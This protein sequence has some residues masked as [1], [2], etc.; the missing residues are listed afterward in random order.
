MT[1][2]PSNT[3]ESD[4]R[5]PTLAVVDR[6]DDVPAAEDGDD[7]AGQ[8]ATGRVGDRL[9]SIRHDRE[10][11]AA[12]PPGA[13]D[14]AFERAQRRVR[15]EAARGAGPAGRRASVRRGRRRDAGRGRVL[16]A[17][18][19]RRAGERRI[20][21]RPHGAEEMFGRGGRAGGVEDQLV[22]L[23]AVEVLEAAARARVRRQHLREHRALHIEQIAEGDDSGDVA[24]IVVAGQPRLQ[25]QRSARGAQLQLGRSQVPASIVDAVVG[26]GADPDPDNPPPGALDVIGQLPSEIVDGV[27]DRQRHRLAVL[28]EQAPLDLAVA[29]HRSVA[30]E[31]IV[32]EIGEHRDLR[33]QRRA[34]LELEARDLADDQVEVLLQ[35]RERRRRIGVP[36]QADPEAGLCQHRRRQRRGRRLAVGAGHGDHRGAVEPPPELELIEHLEP[37]FPGQPQH[38]GIGRYARALDQGAGRGRQIEDPA[39]RPQVRADPGRPEGPA[40]PLRHLVRIAIGCEHPV[41][42]RDPAERI[43]RGSAG[44]AQA[45]DHIGAIGNRRP[46]ART[47]ARKRVE[48]IITDLTVL[49][50]HLREESS[51]KGERCH[52]A[53]RPP[54]RLWRRCLSE[55]AQ[56]EGRPAAATRCGR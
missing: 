26:L 31:V 48:Q 2:R 53:R 56:E 47:Q 5:S 32:S 18:R 37:P 43:H 24:R 38:R 11:R 40:H 8:G 23:A 14:Q 49:G 33:E 19:A 50:S 21:S 1:R 22:V 41:A 6:L 30:W 3:S 16:R 17:L 9:R 7:I 10:L 42:P 35:R 29:A 55:P 15:A 39:L 13:V 36:G 45:G 28:D 46:P 44:L 51:G 4:S 52:V 12:N 25:S 34:A 20:H 54:G 27:D